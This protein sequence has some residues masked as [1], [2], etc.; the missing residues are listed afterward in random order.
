[1]PRLDND[2][3]ITELSKLFLSCRGTGSVFITMKQSARNSHSLKSILIN[4]S[5]MHSLNIIPQSCVNQNYLR[6]KLIFIIVM[7][8]F[9]DFQALSG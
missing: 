2:Q 6:Q 1:M 7:F 8:E 3:F 5:I 4:T 9:V